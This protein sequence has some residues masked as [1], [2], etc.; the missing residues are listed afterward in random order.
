MV[1]GFGTLIIVARSFGPELFGK[2]NYAI[3]FVS[4]FSVFSSLGIERILAR[5]F[6]ADEENALSHLR[7]GFF[8]KLIGGF[9]LFTTAILVSTLI[10]KGDQ[11][12]QLL[13]VIFASISIFQS[14]DVIEYWFQSRMESKFSI[15]AKLIPFILSSIGKIV[16]ALFYPSLVLL[17]CIY[18]SEAILAAI[19][20]FWFYE[21]KHKSFLRLF[22]LARA[23]T[24]LKESLPLIFSGVFVTIYM[25][26]DQVFLQHM[27]SSEAVGIYAAV[28]RVSEIPFFIGTILTNAAFP[29]IIRSKKLSEDTYYHDLQFLFSIVV[30]ISLVIAF[31]T[32]IF[33]P[34]IISIIYGQEYIAAIPVLRV[35]IWSLLFV[36]MGTAQGVWVIGEKYTKLTFIA[37]LAGAIVNIMMNLML[38]PQ[39]GALGASAATLASYAVAGFLINFLFIRTHVVAK[40]QCRSFLPGVL[41]RE[42]L[43]RKVK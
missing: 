28:V 16:I 3:A 20:L 41:W 25:K 32:T 17:G 4:L 14:F 5:E 21:K 19:G 8:L 10:D 12:T 37:T 7:T 27:A 1:I 40:M 35:H 43:R 23:K 36:F 13:V 15:L 38:I 11:T 42:L 9:F 26:I 24:I 30:W 18:L 34:I 22:E 33:S 31:L 6:I 2:L 39:Y 29:I